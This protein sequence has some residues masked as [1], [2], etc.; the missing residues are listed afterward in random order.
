[1][2]NEEEVEEEEDGLNHIFTNDNYVTVKTAG[3]S[4]TQ[5]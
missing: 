1:M 5:S 3:M 2:I 4:N